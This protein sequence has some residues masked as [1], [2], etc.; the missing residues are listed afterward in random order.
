MYNRLECPMGYNYS[1]GG[2]GSA[3]AL[4]PTSG[5]SGAIAGRSRLD[6]G[7]GVYCPFGD[8]PAGSASISTGVNTPSTVASLSLGFGFE[9]TTPDEL[10]HAESLA[11]TCSECD[12]AL[13]VPTAIQP[14]ATNGQRNPMQTGADGAYS[15]AKPL[16]ASPY[17]PRVRYLP[18][19]NRSAASNG[20]DKQLILPQSSSMLI[21][22]IG[23][24]QS[25]AD[26]IRIISIFIIHNFNN[27]K[28]VFQNNSSH[29]TLI[30]VKCEEL[31]WKTNI[32]LLNWLKIKCVE[33]FWRHSIEFLICK[34]RE[35]F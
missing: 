25:W 32:K 5:A 33:N 34:H 8:R 10:R 7:A 18:A 29:F 15:I 27:L 20:C 31:F 28:L 12:S 35:Y 1:I 3:Q 11:F 6:F 19:Y 4:R 23:H 2:A 14:I 9:T 22:V 24:V 17:Q 30:R 21:A 26:S 13:M 16:T